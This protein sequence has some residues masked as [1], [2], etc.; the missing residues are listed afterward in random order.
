MYD[1]FHSFSLQGFEEDSGKQFDN[2]LFANGLFQRRNTPFGQFVIQTNKTKFDIYGLTEE[3][4]PS[5]TPKFENFPKI[6]QGILDSIV[7]FFKNISATIRSEVYC[8][9]IWDKESQDYFIH[10]P[11][12]EVS[13]ATVK[14]T[15]DVSVFNNENYIKVVNVH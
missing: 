7:D 15:T 9:I 1:F 14:Y 4:E 6:P 11:E 5:F 12:Q 3:C 2:S 8:E 10:V 13:G